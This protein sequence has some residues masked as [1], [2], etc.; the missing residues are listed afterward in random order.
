MRTNRVLILIG[1]ALLIVGAR[2]PWMSVPALFGVEGFGYEAIEIG[3]EDNGLTTGGIGLVLLLAGIVWNRMSGL[4]YALLV[5]LLATVAVL[6][7]MGCVQ[8][9]LELDPDVG[10]VAATKVGL[11]VTLV[12]SILALLGAVGAVIG[13]LR[14]KQ[15]L[16][17]RA[18]PAA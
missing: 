8:S 13:A 9:V 12:G 4:R 18:T 14:N 3:W 6:V 17:S 7:V 1:A 16:G 15:R 5:S 10:F 11:Y 2:L